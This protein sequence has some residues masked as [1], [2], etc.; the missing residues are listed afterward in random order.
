MIRAFWNLS[1]YQGVP[2]RPRTSALLAL[3]LLTHRDP[4][5][6]VKCVHLIVTPFLAADPAVLT[7]F[8]RRRWRFGSTRL[9]S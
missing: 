9:D 3:I 5:F 2:W 1:D 4:I 7:S 8:A 6:I